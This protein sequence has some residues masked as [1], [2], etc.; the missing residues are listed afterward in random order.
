[1]LTSRGR[2]MAVA[3]VGFLISWMLFGERELMAAGL[4]ALLGVG[5]G[6]AKVAWDRTDAEIY[7]TISPQHAFVGD[8]ISVQLRIDPAGHARNVRIEDH[9]AGKPQAVFAVDRFR[10]GHELSA[11]YQFTPTRRGVHQVGPAV[12]SV[13]DPLG[14]AH[15]SNGASPVDRII[16]FPPIVPLGG[17]PIS[18]GSESGVNPGFVRNTGGDEFFSLREYRQGDDLR[19]VHWP[20]SA[21]RDTLMIR[22]LQD[23]QNTSVMVL[24]DPRPGSYKTA[25]IF[26]D[27]VSCAASMYQHLFRAGVG[28]VLAVPGKG[29]TR[30]EDFD[31]GMEW[32]AEAGS[33]PIPD[34]ANAV[35]RIDQ[36]VSGG[37]I[38]LMTGTP[39][40]DFLAAARVLQRSFGRRIGFTIGDEIATSPMFVPVP[41]LDHL[42]EIWEQGLEQ[43]WAIAPSG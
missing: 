31:K 5:I 6:L 39:D 15:Q 35:R 20:A 11:R 32:L 2:I 7:R 21:R 26:E 22:Q 4:I 34:F 43:A 25:E 3:G 37:L 18:R 28:P 36:Q 33:E 10:A 16:V 14:V 23:P 38:I 41:D 42:A 19:R 13:G 17:L 8:T 27:A 24:F 40:D 9:V 1:M 30:K 29:V 12:M